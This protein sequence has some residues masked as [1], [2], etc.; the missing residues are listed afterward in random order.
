[1]LLASL[2]GGL[3]GACAGGLFGWV[4]L[5]TAVAPDDLVRLL[6]M[7]GAAR[8]AAYGALAGLASGAIGAAVGG[9]EYV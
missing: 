4:P 3:V 2:L 6:L 1:V 7:L 8:G 5:G 9:D